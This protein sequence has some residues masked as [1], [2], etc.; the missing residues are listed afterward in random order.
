VT[1]TRLTLLALALL[2]PLGGCA[3]TRWNRPGAT[4]AD[5]DHE[6]AECDAVADPTQNMPAAV[7]PFGVLHP[8][9]TP[10]EQ[11]CMRSRGWV[12]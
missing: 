10:A 5:F 9:L 11:S 1:A 3:K 12:P 4:Q 2:L 6:L 7:P 8:V